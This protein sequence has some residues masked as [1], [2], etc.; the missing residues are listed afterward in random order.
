MTETSLSDIQ[1]AMRQATDLI[2]QHETAKPEHWAI[3]LL[4]AFDGGPDD[5]E[6]LAMLK[7][8]HDDI[9]RRLETGEW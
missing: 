5:L 4:E 6:T 9:D 3:W 8:V 1:R 2:R 7:Q